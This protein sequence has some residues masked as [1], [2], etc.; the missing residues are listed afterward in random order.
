MRGNFRGKGE[1]EMN[2]KKNGKQRVGE[3]GEAEW[4]G[5]GGELNSLSPVPWG[6][7]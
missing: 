6:I 3:E 5:E 1:G 7:T 2:T 4:K